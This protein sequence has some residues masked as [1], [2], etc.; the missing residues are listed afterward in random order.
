MIRI[1]ADTTCSL[2]LPVLHKMGV[3][4]LPQ[5]IVFG[6]ES[7]RD[8]TELTSS[9]FLMKLR[10][11]AALPKTAA[12]P[13]SLYA[14]VY[15]ELL[16]KGDAVL[17]LCPS[18]ELSGTLRSAQMAAQDFPGAPLHVVDMRTIAG[19]LGAAVILADRWARQGMPIKEL[20]E[21]L[22]Q[23]KS[24]QQTYFVVATLEYL[25]RGGR[26]GGARRLLGEMLQVKPILRI[27]NG[28]VEPF[29]QQRTSKRA[30]ARLQELIV[31]GCPKGEGS[32]LCIMQADAKE[33]ADEVAGNLK[34][35]LGLKDIPIYEQPPAI[36]VHAGPGTLAVGFYT[37]PVS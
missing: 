35:S 33:A 12:P 28:R 2:P 31:E 9:A 27:Q 29:E 20:L 18:G 25:H 34:Q 30:L 17:V 23:L 5:I 32:F 15:R 11:S 14:P 19:M 3:A 6:E 4:V 24:I 7:F 26:I 8:D 10:S 13:P 36:I 1:V 16:A 21:R 37:Q 22:E